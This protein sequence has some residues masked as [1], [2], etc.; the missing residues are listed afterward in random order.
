MQG[1]RLR[2]EC[3]SQIGRHLTYGIPGA[4]DSGSHAEEFVRDALVVGVVDRDTGML[5]TQGIGFA[6]RTQGVDV[7]SDDG[8]RRQFA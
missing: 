7:G 1:R 4:I 2:F 3:A 6:F 5:Q 8:R